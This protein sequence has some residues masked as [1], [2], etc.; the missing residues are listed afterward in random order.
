M[1]VTISKTRYDGAYLAKHAFNTV[2]TMPTV[3]NTTSAYS[4]SMVF[5][6]SFKVDV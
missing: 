6:I 5:I 2:L 3:Q 1:T 4:I